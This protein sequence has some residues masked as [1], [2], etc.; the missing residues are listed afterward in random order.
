MMFMGQAASSGVEGYRKGENDAMNRSLKEQQ[1]KTMK[2]QDP[3]RTRIMQNQD[4]MTRAQAENNQR[5][6]LA[7]E[8]L[9][10]DQHKQA[11]KA[12]ANKALGNDTDDTLFADYVNTWN[13]SG[14]LPQGS[15]FRVLPNTTESYKMAE[16]YLLENGF[17]AEPTKMMDYETGLPSKNEDGSEMIVTRSE[18][19]AQLSEAAKYLIDHNMLI[20]N[21]DQTGKIT[22]LD[23][24]GL[25][26]ALG[27][28]DNMT[29]GQRMLETRIA[30]FKDLLAGKGGYSKPTHI[31]QL[32]ESQS[33]YLIDVKG[34]TMG[35]P[36]YNKA[37]AEYDGKLATAGANGVRFNEET[38]NEDALTSNTML[39]IDGKADYSKINREQALKNEVSS[40]VRKDS[41]FKSIMK[42]V[43]ET[44]PVL[45]LAKSVNDDIAKATDAELSGEG[46]L[47]RGP[48]ESLAKWSSSFFSSKEQKLVWS[49]EAVKNIM[50]TF[51]VDT[52]LGM[53]VQS[54]VKSISGATVTDAEREFFLTTLQG[55][56]LS[57]P[58]VMK[59][60]LGTFQEVISDRQRINAD[61]LGNMGATYSAMEAMDSIPTPV[62]YKS[63]PTTTTTTDKTYKVGGTPDGIAS[64]DLLSSKEGQASAKE[65]TKVVASDGKTEG[66]IIGGKEAWSISKPLHPSLVQEAQ[67]ID[68]ATNKSWPSSLVGK[69]LIVSTTGKPYILDGDYTSVYSKGK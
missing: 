33:R 23:S 25:Y 66:Y 28:G 12:Q 13:Q 26:A 40:E 65:G 2:E 41:T 35:S 43:N 20:G 39:W 62:E 6:N 15:Q 10:N 34:M 30:G 27:L 42:Q 8:R 7:I 24:T 32:R 3:I 59:R 49:D 46:K 50:N 31:D 45:S 22:P 51:G 47:M 60:T 37:M 61:T 36:E 21:T 11:I 38:A 64:N 17:S 14:L 53:L 56:K 57:D 5:V 58:E 55:G 44:K 1:L 29:E 52:K 16:R 19:Q 9:T 48:V 68:P 69:T 4:N 67:Y 54:Y 63:S 18:K